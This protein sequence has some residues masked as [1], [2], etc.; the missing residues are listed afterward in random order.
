M[1]PSAAQTQVGFLSERLTYGLALL[2]A[3][4]VSIALHYFERAD[5]AP[6][7]GTVDKTVPMDEQA[8]DPVAALSPRAGGPGTTRVSM[9]IDPGSRSDEEGTSGSIVSGPHAGVAGPRSSTPAPVT[10]G[11][12]RQTRGTPDK[13]NTRPDIG[14]HS[15]HEHRTEGP[16]QIGSRGDSAADGHGPGGAGPDSVTQESGESGDTPAREVVPGDTVDA[17]QQPS[18]DSA[19]Y[20]YDE[21]YP[22]CPRTLPPGADPQMAAEYLQ[23]YQCRY[24]E[25]C[26][27]ATAEAEAI[28]TWYLMGKV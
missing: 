15:A 5:P 19:D 20:E 25:S 27:T 24:L 10:A 14:Q 23:L 11:S 4:G 22:G 12:A 8:S 7:A 2:L 1:C 3:F 18:S 26:L 13:G 16:T 21:V 6:G 28:C 9:A 17:A